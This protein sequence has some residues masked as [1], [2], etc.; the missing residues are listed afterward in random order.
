M[1]INE[2]YVAEDET[3]V[4]FDP[5]R[6]E[7]G[8][9]DGAIY[10]RRLFVYSATAE[11]RRFFHSVTF[12]LDEREKANRLAGRVVHARAINPQH[13]VETY[14]V[15]G[16]IAWQVEDNEREMAHKGV[17]PGTVRDF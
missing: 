2:A 4:G 15:Y 10:G 7:L 14:E 5:E 3:I 9:P 16:S 13:W 17:F 8:N 11:G 12:S 6:A 1:K